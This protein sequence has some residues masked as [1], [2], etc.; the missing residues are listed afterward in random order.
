MWS[1]VRR[2]FWQ[3]ADYLGWKPSDDDA[4]AGPTDYPQHRPPEQ[5]Q[6]PHR[7]TNG[8]RP[9]TDEVQG[10]APATRTGPP[11]G[12]ESGQ[13]YHAG[14]RADASSEP[15]RQQQRPVDGPAVH[16]GV[17]RVPVK[18]P[19]VP[20]SPAPPVPVPVQA[21]RPWTPAVL[22][23]PGPV[24]EP[25]PSTASAYRPDSIADG[26]STGHFTVRLASVRG[27]DHR[28]SGAP[29]QDDMAVAHHPRTGAVVFAVADGVSAAPL[30]HIGAT[31]AC[32]AALSSILAGLDSPEERVDWQGLVQAAAWQ[33]CEQ[34][35]LVLGLPEVNR[36]AA[37]EQMATTLVAGMVLPKQAGPEVSL[38]Q[39]GDTSAWRLHGD[40]YY[41]LLDSKHNPDAAVFSSAVT[42]LPRVP[43][44]RA[45]VGT[46]APGE[47][48]LVGTDGFG[49]PL[50]SGR[51]AVGRHF[52]EALAEVPP[53]LK[54]ANDL[55]FSRETFDDDRTLFALWPRRRG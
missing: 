8:V 38:I 32:R 48:L 12:H 17:A 24:F 31:A 30:S 50:G 52:A 27:Y 51:G 40:T 18:T 35:K 6:R 53:I 45:S 28:Y 5:V 10:R 3:I 55:D 41:N 1:D 13:I 4:E 49:D 44:V 39:V 25:K 33:I 2:L 47:T 20:V 37:D 36:G 43:Q 15:L 21:A 14:P 34:A 11:P 46:L 19:Y 9:T 54:F 22:E 16:N 26:W 29:R 23:R 42:A 7:S